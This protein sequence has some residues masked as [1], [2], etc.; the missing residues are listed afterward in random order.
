MAVSDLS[1]GASLNALIDGAHSLGAVEATAGKYLYLPPGYD[2]PV[3]DGFAVYRPK[4]YK[5]WVFLR[6]SVK[7]GDV[8]RMGTSM[9]FY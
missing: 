6:S 5:I 3:P 2:G 7:N 1:S 8:Q 4:T 9:T